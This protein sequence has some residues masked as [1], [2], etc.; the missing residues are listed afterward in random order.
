MMCKT[1]QDPC[2]RRDDNINLDLCQDTQNG[3]IYKAE[4]ANKMQKEAMFFLNMPKKL[5]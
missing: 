5:V 1:N 3:T 4:R 2:F